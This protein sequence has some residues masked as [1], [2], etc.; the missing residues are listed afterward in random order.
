MIDGFDSR[1]PTKSTN[2]LWDLAKQQSDGHVGVNDTEGASSLGNNFVYGNV[3]YSGATI[4]GTS[5]VQGTVTTPFNK[6]INPVTAPTWTSFNATPT[7]ITNTMTLT[8]GTASAPAKYKVSS[9]YIDSTKVVTL[10]PHAA[11]QQSYIEIWVTGDFTSTGSSCIQVQ[12]GVHVTYHVQGNMTV[13]G[14]SF[15]NQT[16]RAANNI[17]NLINPAA[18]TIQA[19]TVTGGGSFI[20]AINAPGANVSI[21]GN[22]EFSGALIGKTLGMTGG[23]KMHYDQALVDLGVPGNGYYFAGFAEAVR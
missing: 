22:G 21:S 2:G 23:A 20:G 14:S 3:A 18:T 6:P 11:G 10:A 1:D 7:A 15:V 16:D 5:N 12:P 8:G 9:L 19:V 13:T 4:L 17:I